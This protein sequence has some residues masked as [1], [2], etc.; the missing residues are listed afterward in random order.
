MLRI[1]ITIIIYVLGHVGL[2]QSSQD[3]EINVGEKKTYQ[4]DVVINNISSD[5][6]N[7]YFALY[8]SESNFNARKPLMK[9]KSEVIGGVAGVSFTDLEPNIYAITC[10]HDANSN[11]KLDFEVGG[12]PTEDYGSTNNIMRFGPPV[13]GD[14]KFDLKDKDLTFEIE[15]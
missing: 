6:G 1:F 14:A 11:G 2:A 10:F 13:F 12:I 4:V 9:G 8:D 7:V 5:K 3:S 15:F